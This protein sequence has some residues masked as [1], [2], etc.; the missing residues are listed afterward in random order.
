M[1]DFLEEKRKEIQARLK[2]LKPLVDEYPAWRPP[3][4]RWPVWAQRHA[5]L[6]PPLLAAGAA[7][8]AEQREQLI[9]RPARAAA[10]VGHPLAA[11]ARAGPRAARHHHSRARRGDGHQAELPLSRDAQLAED[12]QVVKS[13]RG[14]HV[15]DKS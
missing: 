14:W 7:P 5:R 13:G 3:S 4:A 6:L 15:R 9:Q 2:E 11:G 10:R 8:Q 12:G 1:T